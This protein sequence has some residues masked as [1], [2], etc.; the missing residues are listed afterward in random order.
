MAPE[1]V[2]DCPLDLEDHQTTA[3]TAPN[4]RKVRPVDLVRTA[5]TL[6]LCL[7]ALKG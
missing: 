2:T 7:D 1:L 6:Q 3:F 5:A 4:G